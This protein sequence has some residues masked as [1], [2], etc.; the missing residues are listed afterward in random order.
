MTRHDTLSFTSA[1]KVTIVK[2]GVSKDWAKS[3]QLTAAGLSGFT[4]D[5]KPFLITY[6]SATKYLT[7]EVKGGNASVGSSAK[8]P[9]PGGTWVAEEGGGGE[10]KPPKDPGTHHQD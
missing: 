5:N 1:G 3:C 4:L 9:G 2:N 6:N 8:M 10:E 7:C